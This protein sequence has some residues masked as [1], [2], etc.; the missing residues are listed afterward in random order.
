MKI[1]LHI[2]AR[3]KRLKWDDIN[4]LIVLSLTSFVL[5]GMLCLF[6]IST[7]TLLIEK[8]GL[9]WLGID[10]LLAALL[11]IGAAYNICI[12]ITRQENNI[13]KI[14]GCWILFLWF[15]FGLKNWYPYLSLHLLFAVKYATIF[16]LNFIFWHLVAR[17]IKISITSLKFI[18]ICAFELLG[19]VCASGTSFYL[20]ASQACFYALCGLT[21]GA[22]LISILCRLLSVKRETFAQNISGAQDKEGKRMMNIIWALSFFWTIARLLLEF[23]LYSY[24]V[25]NNVSIMPL[26]G[27]LY[28]IFACISLLM[29]TSFARARLLYTIPLGL[30][31]CTVSI[32][33][34]AL[35]SAFDEEWMILGGILAFFISSHFYINR[36]FALLFRPF[37]S[38][39]GA[40][41]EN[42]R[43]LIMMPCA[44]ILVGSLLVDVNQVILNWILFADMGILALLFIISAHLYG[45][46]LVKMCALK[47]WRDGPFLLAYPPLKQMIRQGLSKKQAAE[48]IYFLRIVDE[49]YIANYRALLNQMLT[50]SAITVRLFA[51]KK[52]NKLSLTTKEKRLLSSLVKNDG[53]A[54][55]QNMALACLI[56]EELEIN[57]TRAWHQYKDYLKEKKWILGTC[58]GFLSGRGA[59]IDKV[60]HIV[61][62]LAESTKAQDNELA[63]DIMNQFPRMEW[64]HCLERLLYNPSA[65]VV[66]KAILVAGQLSSTLCLNRLLTLLD[67]IRWR[68]AVLE[69]L[70]QYGKSAFPAIEKTILSQHIP[71]MRQKLLILFLSTLST[72][73]SKQ[74]LMRAFTEANRLLR[75]LL[76]DSLKQPSIPWM[77]SDKK[78]IL[79]TMVQQTVN[80]WLEIHKILLQTENLEKNTLQ[81]VKGLFYEALT[82]EL[83]RTRN[84]LLD[85]IGFYLS[86]SLTQNAIVTLKGTDFN[87]YAAAAGC[88]QDVLSKKIYQKIKDILLYPTINN[89]PGNIKKMSPQTLLNFFILS[90][91][92][93]V[94][95]WLQ[96]LALY[97]W[98]ELNEKAGLSAVQEGLKSADWIVLEAALSALGRLE[99]DRK[100]VAKIVLTIPTRYLL[101]QNFENLLEDKHAHYN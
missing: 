62:D 67:D 59:W 35:G 12:K 66:K 2:W 91:S 71:L 57:P 40:M 3:L 16:L 37:T 75:P 65:T 64:E 60:I 77:Y 39:K 17:Y 49:G 55:V 51:L 11:W 31:V 4:R 33:L 101:N 18:G 28:L 72:T 56:R 74:I 44:F 70:E 93:W 68:D 84:L 25:R 58:C 69:A 97:G 20:H 80:E 98:R 82:E 1:F 32:G 21:V 13:T 86:D 76:V 78:E 43:F 27:K 85:Q 6:D 63:L 79:Q 94:T 87:A 34:S 24:A 5:S 50:H 99:T 95:P 23:V 61:L 42:K 54:E 52:L 90:P 96:A 89:P 8:E 30:V 19:I 29:L 53:C 38:G 15:I 73:D 47:I 92:Q 26:L 100:K 83:Q 81:K 48:V 41:L 7:S 10:Y 45:R 14:T 22:G 88:L 36:Y 9:I 46:Q